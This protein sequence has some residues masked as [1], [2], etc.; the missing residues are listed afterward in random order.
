MRLVKHRARKAFTLIELLVVIAI[1]AIL[2]AMLLP[3]LAKAKERAKRISCL[4]GLKQL[5]I[6]QNMYGMDS[7]GDWVGDTW[8]V[9]VDAPATRDGVDDDLS[10]LWPEYV[11]PDKS[12]V[13]A[14]TRNYIRTNLYTIPGW[15][16]T[17]IADLRNNAL[18]IDGAGTSY[19]CFGTWGV[20]K[21]GER[22]LN[23]WQPSGGF[24]LGKPSPS[25][26]FAITDGDDVGGNGDN[27]NYPDKM[28]NHGADGQNFAFADGHAKF[29]N[30]RDFLFVWNKC[31]NTS[32]TVQELKYK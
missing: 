11:K 16:R 14:G 12:Y 30:R 21:K 6:G 10:W 4:N 22:G 18:V 31:Q 13:C 9:K 1:I 2:A 7:M 19:E 17:I 32:R 24:A 28:D 8:Q 25:D 5:A 27:E 23:A 26:V 15:N 29:I 3:A 20:Y